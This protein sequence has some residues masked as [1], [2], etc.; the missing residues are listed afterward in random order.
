[1]PKKRVLVIE[2]EPVIGE[3][4]RDS[5]ELA[6]YMADVFTDADLA[7]SRFAEGH[8]GLVVTDILMPKREGFELLREFK[9]LSPDVG[10]VAISGGG[11]FIPGGSLLELAER[12]GADAT[13]AKPFRLS[14]LVRL[15][16]E[17]DRRIDLAT[18][19][20][21]PAAGAVQ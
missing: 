5:L 9:K 21:Q 12:L 18:L 16:Q 19:N 6:G 11:R 17:L 3:A 2:D 15:V 13:L 20:R 10:V 8:H 4:I 14:E 7:L 1:M